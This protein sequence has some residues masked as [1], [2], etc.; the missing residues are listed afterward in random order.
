MPPHARNEVTI[1]YSL[2]ERFWT[3]SPS[4]APPPPEPNWA[5]LRAALEA[6]LDLPENER[7]G[8]LAHSLSDAPELLRVGRDMLDRDEGENGATPLERKRGVPLRIGPYLT[9]RTIATGGMGTVYLAVRDDGEFRQ[10]VAIK[11]IRPHMDTEEVLARFRRERQVQAGLSHPSIVRLLDGGAT[12]D[13]LPYLVMEYV[14]GVRID[15]YCDENR[16]TI[17]ERLQL[18]RSVVQAVQHAHGQLV[19]HR[20]IKPSNILVADGVPKL[21]DFGIAKVLDTEKQAQDS[22]VT[23]ETLGFLTPSYASPEQLRG[24]PVTVASDLYS[25]GALLHLLLTGLPPHDLAGLS[26][27]EAQT[28]VT[29]EPV[30]RASS[31]VR[32]R[33]HTPG[34]SDAEAAAAAR[35]VTDRG[36]V[37]A[38]RGDV[39]RILAMCLRQEPLRRYA[40]AAALDDDIAR[41]L[42]NRPVLARTDSWVYRSSRFLRRHR[43][44]ALAATSSILILGAGLAYSRIQNARILR[45][46]RDTTQQRDLADQRLSQLRRLSSDV[47]REAKGLYLRVPEALERTE[48]LLQVLEQHAGQAASLAQSDLPAL[49]DTAELYIA[50]GETRYNS[51]NSHLGLPDKAQVSYAKALELLDQAR[52]LAPSDVRAATLSAQALEQVASGHVVNGDLEDAAACHLQVLE[53]LKPLR[54]EAENA[55]GRLILRRCTAL[56]SLSRVR[57]M[58]GR[59]DDALALAQTNLQAWKGYYAAR[60]GIQYTQR[61]QIAIAEMVV[62][63]AHMYRREYMPALALLEDVETD[64]WQTVADHQGSGDGAR[65]WIMAAREKASVLQALAVPGAKELLAK[66]IEI[67]RAG[68]AKAPDDLRAYRDLLIALL[69]RTQFELDAGPS[70]AAEAA[71]MESYTVAK[72]IQDRWPDLANNQVKFANAQRMLGLL[73]HSQGSLAEAAELI[74]SACRNLRG[75]HE[76]APDHWG[77]R[78]L[79]DT[80]CIDRAELQLTIASG[81]PDTSVKRSA[82]MRAQGYLERVIQATDQDRRDGI[83]GEQSLELGRSARALGTQV[84][85]RLAAL[86]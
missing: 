40:S 61:G 18:F 72:E 27:A 12:A 30:P 66:C 26:L 49:C 45:A 36:L 83:G 19:V 3:H 14:E 44:L 15:R 57:S 2:S 10:Q 32:R 5:R 68:H 47:L 53:M 42:S 79:Y 77:V 59:F 37:R 9:R 43:A 62:A 56:D 25:L 58:Q 65:S 74:G 70:P 85:E 81:D 13:G 35:A 67:L 78:A 23:R 34:G 46:H 29:T 76:A 73:R 1:L 21:L 51:R 64:L 82:L 33:T 60:P 6:A 4:V 55:D 86:D 20:D 16:L 84:A 71:A 48:R 8:A 50:L 80:A 31:T 39:D 52:A 24:A 63:N 28:Q 54:P 75:I 17:P 11:L 69:Q 22:E 38:L 41:H 7:S